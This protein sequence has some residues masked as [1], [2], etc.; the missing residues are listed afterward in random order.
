M[1]RLP[2]YFLIDVSESMVG[3]P[4][5]QVQEGMRSIIQSLRQDP[6]ALET[7]WVSVI[8]FAGKAKVLMPL[9]ELNIVYPPAL[10]IGGGTAMGNALN[11]LMDEI[12]KNRHET[13]LEKKGDWKPIIFLFT[14]GK[15]TDD[16]A[17]AFKRWNDKYRRRC[18]IVAISIGDNINTQILGQLTKDVIMLKKTDHD[19]FKL[20]FKWVTES[21]RMSSLSVST[22]LSDDVKL[23]PIES[24]FNFEKVKDVD[25]P[26]IV[27]ENFA[28]ILGKC[29]H[30]KQTYL[31]KFVRR[32]QNVEDIATWS[33]RGF[34]YVGSYIVD[35]REYKSLSDSSSDK[36]NINSSLLSGSPSCPCCG[37]PMGLVV[38]ECGH[39]FC[40]GDKP[41]VVCP[42]CN[43]PGKLS[44]VG[45]EGID[46][47]RTIG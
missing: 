37:N 41:E 24:R 16:Y 44:A 5:E 31:L 22:D 18:S 21:L 14:D 42:W 17:K 13:T 3:H 38:C 6:F 35:E 12:D 9:T 28:V 4:I 1:R 26:H 32:V 2:V 40:A 25:N 10:N 46:V 34:G 36:A 39:V 27:D 7:V 43:A 19:S 20:F 47:N 30:T 29:Q 23:A 45:S 8:A 33:Q 11:T 15:P